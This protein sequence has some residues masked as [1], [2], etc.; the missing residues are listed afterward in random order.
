[1]RFVFQISQ[2]PKKN[3]P[4]N[5]S[6]LEIQNFRPLHNA[7]MGRN[8]EFQVQDFFWIFF[9]R[10]WEIWKTNCTFWKKPPLAWW[11]QNHSKVAFDFSFTRYF[12]VSCFI[13]KVK[14]KCEITK[15]LN[16]L[17]IEK[18][19]NRVVFWILLLFAQM[20]WG[21]FPSFLKVR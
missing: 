10:D 19:N 6:E 14:S 9:F 21:Y 3:I 4:K 7:V 12:W 1:M 8:F 15:V 5:Y 17:W 11:D 18:S 2:S 20:T 16:P 13:G